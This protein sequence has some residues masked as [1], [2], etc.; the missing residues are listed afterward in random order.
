M[1]RKPKQITEREL[2]TVSKT[3]PTGKRQWTSTVRVVSW[4]DSTPTLEK[5]EHYSDDE[6]TILCGKCRGLN[7]EDFQACLD[8]Q[9]EIMAALKGGGL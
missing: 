6:G 2:L 9:D 7:A 8:V 4:N 1:A 5:R 3:E